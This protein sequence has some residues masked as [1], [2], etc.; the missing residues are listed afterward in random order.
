MKEAAENGQTRA[1][2]DGFGGFNPGVEVTSDGRVTFNKGPTGVPTYP[3]L[4]FWDYTYRNLRDAG[5]A[6]TVAGRGNEGGAITSVAS[7]LRNELDDMVPR[8]RAARE[9][10]ASFFGAQDALEAG[11]IFA[12]SRMENAGAQRAVDRMNPAERQLFMR[13]YASQLINRINESGDNR[14]IANVF[15]NSPAD[16]QRAVI[17]LGPDRATEL[18]AYVR[19]ERILT[20]SRNAV[21]GNSTT[22]RQLAELGLAGGAYGAATGGDVTHPTPAG[23]LA[24]ALA[25]GALRGKTAINQ[26]VAQRVGEMLVSDDPT[27]LANGFQILGRDTGFLR[28]L[29]AFDTASA[30]AAGNVTVPKM[31]GSQ[32]ASTDRPGSPRPSAPAIASNIGASQ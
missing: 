25:Y 5:R 7:A 2:A 28:A 17:A 27:V 11:Q 12:T 23:V 22:A 10:A 3:D 21:T 16:R 15:G 31:I 24:A 18:E 6:A 14:N 1:V 29:R 4:Q 19:A 26:R 8:F 32:S 30:T 13:G 9:G 20:A